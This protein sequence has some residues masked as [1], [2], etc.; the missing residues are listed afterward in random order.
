MTE[1]TIALITLPFIL[2]FIIYL[3]P[4][5]DRCLALGG[6]IVTVV[7][8]FLL[9]TSEAPVTLKLLDS[10][11]VDLVADELS[12]F[13]MLT[14]ALVTMAVILCCWQTVKTAYFYAKVVIVH[15]S[16]NAAFICADFISLYVAL[17]ILSI[18]AFL[19][20][21]YPRSGK[22]FWVGLRYLFVS[23]TAM[24][25][26]LTGVALVY[27]EH[28]SFHFSG[29][30]GAA[31]EAQALILLGLL[32]KGGIFVSGL[33]L[34]LTHAEADPPVSALLSAVVVKAAVFPLVRCALM[35]DTV[36]AIVR[37][38]GVGTAVLG[39]AYAVFEK[40][41][42]RMLAF[43]TVSQ[44]GFILAAPAVGG[45]YALTHG[46]A[47]GALFLAAG[48]LPAR[49]L[50]ELKHKPVDIRVW[51]SLA[52]AGFSIAGFPLLAGFG[53]KV[54]TMQHLLSWQVIGMTC[55]AL[56]TAVTF[57]RFIFLTRG[58]PTEKPG[59]G[60]WAGILLL[61]TGLAVANWFYYQTYTLDQTIKP[62]AIVFVGWVLYGI[63]FRRLDIKF[64]RT[65]E[66][67]DH[68]IGV[69]SL[70]L[71]VLFWMVLA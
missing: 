3:S 44:L 41:I 62:L 42:K 69:M 50:D 71:I 10:F 29:L 16:V 25:F 53:A 40:D 61:L 68:L 48:K 27:Q 59:A 54:V 2:G 17:E 39:I 18:A 47:K 21:T 5:L 37:I 63:I 70:V 45:G 23:N 35:L 49:N 7:Y 32:T 67:F 38:F 19:L 46:L 14:N 51:L 13:F 20:I 56:G 55:V 4:G 58:G 60:F 57:A 9:F 66:N 65:P 52:L 22:A 33:W 11:G 31:P 1:P 8:S 28:H 64:P 30:Q 34:P 15:G 24:L 36:E 26:Y 6:A 43:S 12:G